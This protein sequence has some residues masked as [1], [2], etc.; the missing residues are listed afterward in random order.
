MAVDAIVPIILI[1]GAPILGIL[2]AIWLWKR[3]VGSATLGARA[4]RREWERRRASVSISAPRIS[5]RKSPATP[6]NVPDPPGRSREM[7]P[8]RP[9]RPLQG[10]EHPHGRRPV[11][12]QGRQWPRVPAGG[13]AARRRGGKGGPSGSA[14]PPRGSEAEDAG[15]GRWYSFGTAG[16]GA[17][18]QPHAS[19]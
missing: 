2:F 15:D 19:Y 16:S 5:A 3:C 13:G 11:R 10:L 7:R 6:P 8:T 9:V 14:R 18:S 17:A 4:L 12:S 1:P